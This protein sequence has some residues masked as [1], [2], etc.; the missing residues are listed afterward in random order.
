M[1]AADRLSALPDDVLQHILSFAPAKR[2]AS[3]AV[4]SRRWRPVWRG[5]GAVILDS[6]LYTTAARINPYSEPFL[7]DAMK[8]LE[9]FRRSG[10]ELRRLTLLLDESAYWFMD[11]KDKQQKEAGR[12]RIGTV[13]LAH[14]SAVELEELIVRCRAGNVQY[15]HRPW[16]A[17]LPCGATLRVLELTYCHIHPP[18]LAKA[19]DLPRLTD[20]RL[21]SCL[22]SEGYLQ[23]VVDAAPALTNLTMV[24]VTYMPAEKPDLMGRYLGLRDGFSVRLRLRCPTVT[25]LELVTRGCAEELQPWANPGIALDM[26]SLRSFRYN[27]FPVKLSLTSPTPA[28]TRVHL[29][30]SRRDHHVQ[31]Y[32]P[33]SRMLTSFSSTRALKLR[34]NCIEEAIL[35]PMFPSL[36]LLEVEGRYKYMNRNTA[37]SMARLL[38]SCPAMAELRLRLSMDYAWHYERKTEDPPGG[39][40]AQSMERFNRL[41]SLPSAHRDIVVLGEVSDLRDAMTSC[42]FGCLQKS[43]RKVTL[44][45]KAK[46]VNCFEVQLAKF[47]VE[48]AM[49]LEEMHVDDGEQFC[50]DHLYSK[51]ARWRADSFRR[52][53]LPDTGG[54]RVY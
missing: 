3:T 43:L 36:E 29:D 1:A 2:G 30:V 37:R 33:T 44:K 40:F 28:L 13:V 11:E 53:N 34:L 21:H 52:R 31:H 5:A 50:P 26:P 38:G 19:P 42:T 22:I 27:G 8:A 17:S 54:F 24:Y 12:D 4:L 48:N 14:P 47:I 10:T 39:P 6:N 35:L 23:I 20:L 45:F 25:A 32:E 15:R 41:S 51:V 16:L 18:P 46:E 7:H 9:A 49:V